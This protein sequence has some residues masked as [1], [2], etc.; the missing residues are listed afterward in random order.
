MD[1][2]RQKQIIKKLLEDGLI[3]DTIHNTFFDTLEL[4]WMPK[5]ADN[6]VEN[7]TEDGDPPKK[8]Q[9]LPNG[10]SKKNT[11]VEDPEHPGEKVTLKNLEKRIRDRQRVD[12]V[13]GKLSN[14]PNTISLNAWYK[15]KQAKNKVDPVS[16][17]PSKKKNAILK[18][19]WKARQLVDPVHGKPSDEGDAISLCC[20]IQRNRRKGKTKKRRRSKT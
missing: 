8:R 3:S 17:E 1:I 4:E 18:D 7:G 9:R 11:Y 16:G 12:P 6:S 5:P 20:F 10:K 2:N 15:R 19:T 13:N 14:G